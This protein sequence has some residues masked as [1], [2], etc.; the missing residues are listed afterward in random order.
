MKFRNPFKNL[1]LDQEEQEIND[2]IESGKLRLVALPP[3]E[4]KKLQA[5]AKATLDKTRNINI[6]LTERDLLRI[7]AKSIEEGIPYQTLIASIIHKYI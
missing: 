1:K 4:K 2:A 3:R 7:K 5:A 6:R